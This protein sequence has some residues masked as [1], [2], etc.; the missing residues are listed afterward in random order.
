MQHLFS[1]PELYKFY[2]KL[3]KRSIHVSKSNNPHSPTHVW[4]DTF[5]L[6]W[7]ELAATNETDSKSRFEIWV[8]L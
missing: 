7:C 3:H 2:V 8:I 5:N 1:G 6:I 4:D